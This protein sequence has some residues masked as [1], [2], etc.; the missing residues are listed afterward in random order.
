MVEISPELTQR[1]EAL[2][3]PAERIQLLSQ[4]IEAKPPRQLARGGG[5]GLEAH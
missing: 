5:V 3:R 4:V 2:L 1:L